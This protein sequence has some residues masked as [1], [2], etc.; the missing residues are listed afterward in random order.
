[1]NF[2]ISVHKALH[3]ALYHVKLQNK[4]EL[5]YKFKKQKSS[6]SNQTLIDDHKDLYCNV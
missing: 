3:W 1:M 5:Y 4:S 2:L 6:I